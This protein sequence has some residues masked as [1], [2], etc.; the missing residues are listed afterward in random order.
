MS[1]LVSSAAFSTTASSSQYRSFS[2]RQ[3]ISMEIELPLWQRGCF[4]R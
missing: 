3:H 4:C 2:Y 1:V